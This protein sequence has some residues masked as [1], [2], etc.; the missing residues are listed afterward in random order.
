MVEI[1]LEESKAIMLDILKEVASFCDEHNIL[2]TLTYGTLI[3]AA[4]HKGF[5]PWDDDIDIAMPRPDYE[6]FVKLYHE[7][8]NYAI[9]SPLVDK[10]CFFVY[11]KVYDQRTIKYE[12]GIDYSRFPALGVDIDVFP[13]DG[14]PGEKYHKKYIFLSN[15]RYQ[16]GCLV[17]RSV[18]PRRKLL[19]F[20]GK[21][22]GAF[23]DPLCKMI[24]KDFF[25]WLYI[26]VAKHFKYE[27]CEYVHVA[28]PSKAS[29]R[30]KQARCLF[31][32]MAKIQFEDSLFWAPAKF[33]EYLDGMCKNFRIL[34]PI[35]QRK[36]HHK[37]NIFWKE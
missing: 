24:G 34:P 28:F 23:L 3:G 31:N 22:A 11:T 19:T 18:S 33:D 21:L 7:K 8:G 26:A 36:T 17:A 5:I 10:G 9:S 2:Y 4:R 30:T 1:S 35:E 6:R 15:I 37:N 16:L 25:I 29:F 14:I 12:S 13:I 32:D 20:K 27:E